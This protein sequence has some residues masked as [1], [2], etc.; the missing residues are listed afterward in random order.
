[1]LVVVIMVVLMVMFMFMFMFGV[2]VLYMGGFSTCDQI[3]QF[4]RM[5]RFQRIQMH[6][7]GTIH[8][9]AGGL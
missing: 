9:C 6:V 1:M 4:R 3:Q 2:A 8:R 5:Q 7:N